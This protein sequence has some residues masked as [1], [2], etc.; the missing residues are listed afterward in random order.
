MLVQLTLADVFWGARTGYYGISY[1]PTAC[2]NGVSD[3]WPFT[4]LETDYQAHAAEPSPLTISITEN[5]IG[6]FTA[7]LQAEEEIADARFCMVATLDEYVPAFGGS[8]SHLPYHA[9]AFM[10]AVSG[11]ALSMGVG[12]KLDITKGFTV[13]PSW[14]YSKMGVACWVQKAGGTNPS[15]QPYGDIPIKNKV[16]Q[17]AWVGAMST[18]VPDTDVAAALSLGS[19]SPNP[20]RSRSVMTFFLPAPAHATL[21][22]FDVAGR[23]V[24]VVAE[25]EMDA[26]EHEATWNGRDRAGNE[27]APGIYFARLDAGEQGAGRAKIVKLR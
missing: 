18:D 25:G 22:I 4:W 23:R 20:F 10:T 12:E 27:C 6:D 11:D 17:A 5:G 14:D 19:P 8:Q 9:V 7:H 16:L 1:V 15:P 26:G 24:A 13:E 21:E 3:V 2:G